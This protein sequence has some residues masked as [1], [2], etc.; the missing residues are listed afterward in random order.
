M[1]D[2]VEPT[3]RRCARSDPGA[4]SAKDSGTPR[5]VVPISSAGPPKRQ[6]SRVPWL[7]PGDR[8]E[9][10]DGGHLDPQPADVHHLLAHVARHVAERRQRA[11]ERRHAG[12]RAPARSGRPRP[13]PPAGRRPRASRPRRGRSCAPARTAARPARPAWRRAAPRR[14]RPRGRRGRRTG[15]SSRSRSG[16]RR[17]PS[18]W[19][20]SACGPRRSPPRCA[21]G[22]RPWKA[23]THRHSKGSSCSPS[24]VAARASRSS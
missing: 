12:P 11:V 13:A 10:G 3:M 4:L 17:R 15:S 16:S 24:T 6:S 18:A 7:T 8:R 5:R 19:S 21:S 23:V 1:P 20:P 14:A 9:P 22:S 2:P